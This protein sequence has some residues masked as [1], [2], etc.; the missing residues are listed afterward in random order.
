M[1]RRTAASLA[2]IRRSRLRLLRTARSELLAPTCGAGNAPA[3]FRRFRQ[4]HPRPLALRGVAADV[5]H[6]C[7]HV[8]HELLLAASRQRAWRSDDLHADDSWERLSRGLNRRW[9]HPVN[10]RGGVLQMKRTG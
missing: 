8:L 10:E 6:D 4:K 1:R 2:R 7:G 3:T 9:I 5:C